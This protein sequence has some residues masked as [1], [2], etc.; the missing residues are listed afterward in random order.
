MRMPKQP[1]HHGSC[2]CGSVRF[3]LKGKLDGVWFCHCSQCR[4]NYGLYGAFVGVPRNQ[5]ALK[6]PRMITW[7]QSFP[8]VRRGFCKKCGSPIMWDHKKT[9]IYVCPGLIQG[10]LR[11]RGGKHIFLQ[12]RGYYYRIGDALPGY[13]TNPE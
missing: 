9:G 4:K 2:L 10:K 11:M 8:R 3:T 13:K 6:N 7:Y 12:D 5:F 1:I